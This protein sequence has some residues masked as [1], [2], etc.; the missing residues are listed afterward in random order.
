MSKDQET[1]V[2]L[3]QALVCLDKYTRAR[4]EL[5]DWCVA[6]K[7]M[8]EGRLREDGKCVMRLDG[9]AYLIDVHAYADK[10]ITEIPMEE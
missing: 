7:V 9:R 3:R 4:Q 10:C 2:A 6:L 8:L 1:L 5:I